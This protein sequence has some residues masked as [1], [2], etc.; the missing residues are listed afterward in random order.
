MLLLL[1][2]AK[3]INIGNGLFIVYEGVC[4]ILVNYILIISKMLCYIT[5]LPFSESLS[6]TADTMGDSRTRRHHRH[7][8][9]APVWRVLVTP[10]PM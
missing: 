1:E 10:A 6:K 2:K 8:T 5:G 9:F 3:F 7:C 4:M